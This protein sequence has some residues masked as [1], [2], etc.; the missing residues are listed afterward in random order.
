MAIALMHAAII[1]ARFAIARESQ[2]LMKRPYRYR[3]CTIRELSVIRGA[4]VN[5]NAIRHYPT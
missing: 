4:A 3:P 1:K 5:L 2:V